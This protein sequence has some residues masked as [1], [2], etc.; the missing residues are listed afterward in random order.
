[1]YGCGTMGSEGRRDIWKIGG[2]RWTGELWRIM[3]R[4]RSRGRVED[5]VCDEDGLCMICICIDWCLY[6][7][8]YIQHDERRIAYPRI[9]DFSSA[10]ASFVYESPCNPFLTI[11]L[12]PRLQSRRK[13]TR[14]NSAVYDPLKLVKLLL[15]SL[16]SHQTGLQH[17]RK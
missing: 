4:W 2:S 17:H 16:L 3:R 8:L 6:K 14:S 10:T 7:S 13:R 12:S 15:S 9:K 5:W 11:S 1:M